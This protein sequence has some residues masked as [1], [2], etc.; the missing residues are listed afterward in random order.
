M[1]L[2]VLATVLVLTDGGF[3]AS[4][5]SNSTNSTY[6]DP[7]KNFCQRLWHQCWWAP[8]TPIRVRAGTQTRKRLTIAAVVKDDVL[9]I[10]GGL[11]VFIPYNNHGNP[12][13]GIPI[14]GTSTLPKSH[15]CLKKKN[16][17]T[18]RA[19]TYMVMVGLNSSWNWQTNISITA[20]NKTVNTNTGTLP[21]SNVRGAMYAGTN[22][23]SN[24]YSYGGTSSYANRS[25][26]GFLFPTAPTY[27]LW[28]FEAQEKAWGQYDISLDV[29]IRPAGGAYAEVTGRGM[30]FYLNGF[31]D[32]GSNPD[33]QY[34]TDFRR[35]LDGLVVL[36]TTTQEAKNLS[37]SSLENY[38]R[39]MGGLVYLPNI[40]TEGIL[41]SMG[42]VTKPTSND[43]LSDMGTYIPFDSVDF[44]DVASIDNG[45]SD[46]N[47][48]SQNTTG[49]IPAPRTDFCLVTVS[50][51]D[52][53]SHSIYLYGGK[54]EEN[55]YDQTYVLSIPSFIW[56]KIMEGASPRYAHSCHVVGKSQMLT[57][58]CDIEFEEFP[59]G[60]VFDYNAGEYELPAKIINVI[61]GSATG[62]ATVTSPP[63]GFSNKEVETYFNNPSA[64]L[65]A[66]KPH[67]T[68]PK[69]TGVAIGSLAGAIILLGGSAY[70][71]IN[72]RRKRKQIAKDSDQEQ[73]M[74]EA[75]GQHNGIYEAPPDS[76]TARFARAI[77]RNRA[78][79]AELEPHPPVVHEMDADPQVFELPGRNSRVERGDDEEDKKD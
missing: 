51:P 60:N 24:V 6:I 76:V 61:G 48:Y 2:L 54:G 27:T 20:V 79:R 13:Q 75:P 3:G 16:T 12:E 34:Y 19:D 42:G 46:G 11:E 65:P 7:I 31:I 71:Y 55:V 56:I 32:N 50:A 64:L 63:S 44:L 62:N 18:L 30:G 23:D 36:N 72:N 15:P 4:N 17:L 52:N 29:P 10:D 47:W 1:W 78:R 57:E 74:R 67:L 25:F 40:G 9:Y 35:Y 5:S 69:I 26:P 70:Y 45:N 8:I 43:A 39:A 22:E 33:Y 38:P 58:C 41:V 49:D 77:F 53:S 28:S 14:V 68:G 21:P 66:S 59:M 37:T 73:N